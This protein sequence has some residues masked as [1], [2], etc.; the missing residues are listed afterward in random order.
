M[1]HAQARNES[2]SV[3]NEVAVV[4]GATGFVGGALVRQLLKQSKR[5]VVC[6]V[7][8]DSQRAA[9][10]RGHDRLVD[11][12]GADRARQASH[13][14]RWI[15]SDI[16]ETRLGWDPATWRS[17]AAST[18]EIFH[19]AASVSFDLAL[20]DAHHINVEGTKNVYQLAQA[21]AAHHGN[22]TRFHHVSTAY[23]A[24]CARGRVDANYLP[25]DRHRNFR[26]TYERTKAR[27]ERWLR[28]AATDEAPVSIYRPSIIAGDSVTGET[29]NWNVLYVPMKMIARGSMPLFTTGGRELIDTVAIDVLVRAMVIFSQLDT[30]RV[31]AH[32]VTAGPTA[33]TG[34][35]VMAHTFE[36][37]SLA[38][39]T[40]SHTRTLRP[41][42]WAAL[43]LGVRAASRLPKRAGKIRTKARLARRMLE[44]CAVY[45]PYTRVDVIFDN[46]REQDLLRVFGVEMPRSE[47]YLDTII[48]YALR[49]DFG[50]RPD[51]PVVNAAA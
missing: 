50:R 34:T 35:E 45:V 6:L 51:R 17:L 5:H 20:A 4:T 2:A 49:S 10:A 14:V 9:E 18:V 15:R 33:F 16:A 25:A 39:L 37:A 27:A 41:A 48:D 38:G 36:R 23:V 46:H 22:F 1:G 7:R 40:P 43:G 12:L 28:S 21:A 31:C 30:D 47:V 13:R 29:D 8:A 19:C 3:N 32:H 26:N 11:L 24:G 44:Q 42:A